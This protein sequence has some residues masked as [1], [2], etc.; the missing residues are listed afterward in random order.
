MVELSGHIVEIIERALNPQRCIWRHPLQDFNCFA[1][2][3]FIA[4]YL[5]RSKSSAGTSNNPSRPVHGIGSMG[6]GFSRIQQN[7]PGHSSRHSDSQ[8]SYGTQSII[9]TSPTIF[10]RFSFL[11]NFVLVVHASNRM[12]PSAWYGWS[13][14]LACIATSPRCFVGH[15][16]FSTS[17]PPWM[18][19]HA[20]GS[21]TDTHLIILIT[22]SPP[23]VHATGR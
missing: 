9:V 2:S 22:E 3:H 10:P 15:V 19:A 4:P 16:R 12:S 11:S 23:P 14:I 18:I 1:N 13:C 21:L 17:L 7:A 5:K 6:I 8:M 20:N